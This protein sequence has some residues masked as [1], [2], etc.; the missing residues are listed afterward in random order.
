M[1]DREIPDLQKVLERMFRKPAGRPGGQG[2]ALFERTTA[3][4][5]SRP[6]SPRRL[7]SVLKEGL[8]SR[9]LPLFSPGYGGPVVGVDV[10][11]STLKIV[12]VDSSGEKPVVT[13]AALE[14]A[15]V[16][17]SDREKWEFFCEKIRTFKRRGLLSGRI[18]LGVLEDRMSVEPV[19]MPKMP[20]PD[21]QKAV[22]WEAKEK[23][24]AEAPKQIVKHLVMEERQV[25]GRAQWEILIF[26]VP[27]EE[28]ARPYQM[29]SGYGSHIMAAEPGIM[30]ST[31]A[32]DAAGLLKPGKFV[33]VLDIGYRHS[34]LALLIDRK[35]CFIRAF[36]IAGQAITEN[37]AQYCKLDIEMAE[38]RKREIGLPQIGSVEP[39][40][41]AM[42]LNR[43]IAH[44]MSLYL[45]ELATEVDH[46]LR[47]VTYYSVGRGRA[48]V[49]ENLYLVGGG[50]LL[51]NF[52]A[53]LEARLNT[54]VEVADPFQGIPI[55]DAVKPALNSRFLRMRLA[56]ALGLALRPSGR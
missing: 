40:P 9:V 47:Y 48:G 18:V 35:V 26:A 45:E 46:S 29:I 13:G 43:Q 44:A 6:P 27:R 10:G 11:A 20:E 49:L 4:G 1:A 12:R 14:E 24:A 17:L 8:F 52:P 56:V 33:G 22:L 31:A 23:M 54:K 41:G 50:G 19:T 32:I 42:D 34:T 53:F 36:S 39:N 2:Q 15:P 55:S 30:A 3:S 51:K 16:G 38:Q 37:I 25:E 5:S 21:L 7:A 28:V